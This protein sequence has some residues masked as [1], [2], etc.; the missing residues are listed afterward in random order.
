MDGSV[1]WISDI[2]WTTL[3]SITAR[4]LFG[5]IP[6]DITSAQQR[7]GILMRDAGIPDNA[8]KAFIGIAS[9]EK[10]A[11]AIVPTAGGDTIIDFVESSLGKLRPDFGSCQLVNRDLLRLGHQEFDHLIDVGALDVFLGP[12]NGR[13]IEYL[14]S[15][16]LCMK[17]N[18]RYIILTSSKCLTIPTSWPIR[19][20]GP[21]VTLSTSA[22]AFVCE[23]LTE[24]VNDS[25]HSES[26]S[27]ADTPAIEPLTA[28]PDDKQVSE[29][30][31]EDIWTR[32][33]NLS[34][35]VDV[36]IQDVPTS[37]TLDGI[38]L[39]NILRVISKVIDRA[40]DMQFR[41]I[42]K[43][44]EVASVISMVRRMEVSTDQPSS[45]CVF[46]WAGEG[47]MDLTAVG[48]LSKHLLLV[49][50]DSEDVCIYV[51]G[52]NVVL[53]VDGTVV[54]FDRMSDT[55]S[56]NDL[57]PIISAAIG[58]FTQLKAAYTAAS[59][60]GQVVVCAG[61]IARALLA[62]LSAEGRV[63]STPSKNVT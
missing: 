53:E 55:S 34:R 39:A 21:S 32:L 38:Q 10:L 33:V 45:K 60:V 49:S 2:R 59:I 36:L 40:C 1:E 62:D 63:P 28:D 9:A 41:S 4:K 54:T 25:V 26:T 47:C 35:L 8:P 44:S 31:D 14:T 30:E 61:R 58:V 15:I 7:L 17:P 13:L 11:R 37:V 50:K 12:L 5:V 57:Q 3:T 23:P 42:L 27:V 16:R 20:V 29:C 24:S 19:Q 56:V 22:T 46:E 52:P 51:D 48:V 43:L 18:G 6:G